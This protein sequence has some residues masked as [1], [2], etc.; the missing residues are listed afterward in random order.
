MELKRAI[1][2]Q[3]LATDKKKK[4]KNVS[5]LSAVQKA[6][7]EVSPKNGQECLDSP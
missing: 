5:D 1:C 4:H 6:V 7:F 3:Y 2:Q